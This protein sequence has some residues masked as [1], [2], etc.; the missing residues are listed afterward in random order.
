LSFFS[1]HEPRDPFYAMAGLLARALNR[2]YDAR[3]HWGKYFPQAGRSETGIDQADLARLY[4]RLP[5]FRALCQ[6]YDARGALRNRYVASVLGF[7]VGRAS[8]AKSE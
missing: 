2:L 3:P 4:P 5:D 8:D 6:R 7:D 1:Y